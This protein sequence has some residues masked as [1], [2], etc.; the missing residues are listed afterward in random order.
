MKKLISIA[1]LALLSMATFAE[2]KAKSSQPAV[3]YSLPKTMVEVEVEVTKTVQQA[4]PYYKYS[5]RYLA[6]KDVIPEDKTSYSITDVKV[7]AKAIADASKSFSISPNENYLISVDKNGI[8][9]GVNMEK[10]KNMPQPPF[11]FGKKEEKHPEAKA[12]KSDFYSNMVLTEEQ[13]AA[14]STAKMAELA[15]KQIYRIRENRIALLSG[16]N[17]KMPADGES[18]KL[19]LKGM[20]KMEKSLVE[21]FAG[22][23]IVAVEK[24]SFMIDPSSD[25]KNQVL[26]RLS[27]INGLVAADDL[28]GGPVYISVTTVKNQTPTIDAKQKEVL[29]YTLPGSAKIIVTQDKETLAEKEIPVAQL[30]S[31]Q[32]IPFSLFKKEK[33]SVQYNPKTGAVVEMGK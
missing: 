16:E 8:I 28:S 33:M 6:L 24:K 26:C 2:E 10:E 23:K 19:M 13:L 32:A 7:H 30:G 27:S 14:N 9:T 5:E 29:Y 1:L 31:L 11:S 20:D 18:L 4:G 3:Y 12:E 21:L 15:A 17:D 22:K 25:V